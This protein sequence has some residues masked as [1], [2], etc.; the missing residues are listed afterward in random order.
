MISTRVLTT[1]TQLA[2]NDRT[3]SIT[4]VGGAL[5]ELAIT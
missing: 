4:P 3:E 5:A 1:A 2:R